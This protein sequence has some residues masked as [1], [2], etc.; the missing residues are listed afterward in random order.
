MIKPYDPSLVTLDLL[1]TG[2]Y[3]NGEP[4]SNYVSGWY[5]L[6]DFNRKQALIGLLQHLSKC[7]F[8]RVVSRGLLSYE[9]SEIA[10]IAEYISGLPLLSL[11]TPYRT[12]HK[13]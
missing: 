6:D 8:S 4:I 13:T 10:P 3:V 5:E 12:R 2:V 1:G 7:G 9:Q 11:R